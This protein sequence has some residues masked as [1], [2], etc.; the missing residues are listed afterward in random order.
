MA[1]GS[2]LPTR[3]SGKTSVVVILADATVALH[4]LSNNSILRYINPLHKHLSEA[5]HPRQVSPRFMRR[6]SN[7]LRLISYQPTYLG[8]VRY[9]S[10]H[11]SGSPVWIVPFSL[12]GAHNAPTA[13]HTI[14][15]TSSGVA[16]LDG[17]ATAIKVLHL[18]TTFHL[19][20][21]VLIVAR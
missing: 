17:Y 3:D 14:T 7:S 21:E 11:C 6:P 18:H 19:H 16:A 2:P 4:S 15:E 5:G 12:V 20:S 9:G 1:S 13:G 10:V 8:L